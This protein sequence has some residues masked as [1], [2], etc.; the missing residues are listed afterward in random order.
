MNKST[1]DKWEELLKKR[2]WTFDGFF[3][4]NPEGRVDKKPP[5]TLDNLF[6]YV[7]P[8]VIRQEGYYLINIQHTGLHPDIEMLRWGVGI[9]IEGIN[10]SCVDSNDLKDA[11]LNACYQ[12]L[13]GEEKHGN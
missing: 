1:Q 4:H 2:G 10:D 3:W 11:L 12:A 9:R 7:V 6:K 13:I 8:E 5:L